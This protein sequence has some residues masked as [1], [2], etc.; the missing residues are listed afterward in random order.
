M[1]RQETL[2]TLKNARV[3]PVV[4]IHD[5]SQAVDLA[6]AIKKGG[7]NAI[8]VTLRTPDA[9]DAIRRIAKA[10]LGM[11]LGAGTL[12]SVDDIEWAV[13]AGADFLVT[14]AT[15]A[16]LVPHLLKCGRPALPGVATPTEAL[17]LHLKGFEILKLFPAEAVGG[18]TLL[19][20]LSAPLPQLTFMPT[21]GITLETA[22]AYLSLPNVM[23]VGGSWLVPSELPAQVD[24]ASVTAS[25]HATKD[26]LT[27]SAK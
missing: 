8:E 6:M 16:E 22:P 18:V 14:P 21:G 24:W 15:P 23:A 2:E 26:R 11:A 12:T 7:I 19:K 17:G 27:A 1:N 5:A 4:T 3:V 20:S 10:D 25:V 9:R 13:D